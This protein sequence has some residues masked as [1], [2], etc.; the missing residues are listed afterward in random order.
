MDRNLPDNHKF[1][2]NEGT[3]SNN[4][5]KMY[6]FVKLTDSCMKTIETYTKQNK[7]QNSLNKAN[8]KFHH[9]GGVRNNSFILVYCFIFE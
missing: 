9:H 5:A 2:L 6:I 3:T 8:I 7:K 1:R 4:S